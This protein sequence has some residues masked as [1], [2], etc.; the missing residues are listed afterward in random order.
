MRAPST[1]LRKYVTTW[2]DVI[3]LFIEWRHNDARKT[4]INT[5]TTDYKLKLWE[6]HRVIHRLRDV[7]TKIIIKKRRKTKCTRGK[8]YDPFI[9]REKVWTMKYDAVF[10]WSV[11]RRPHKDFEMHEIEPR[12]WGYF[13]LGH[14]FFSSRKFSVHET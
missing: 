10:K 9:R 14:S 4:C 8:V 12:F 6:G 3:E 5:H 7:K 11:L 1:S 13:L 2:S